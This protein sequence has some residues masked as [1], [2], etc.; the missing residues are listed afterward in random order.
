MTGEHRSVPT[1]RGAR[2]GV[3]LAA[4][5][6]GAWHAFERAAALPS[7]VQ[8]AVPILFFGD[9][10]T[11]LASPLR[12]LTV[13]LNPSLHEFPEGD[14]FRRFPLGAGVTRSEPDR[15]LDALSSYFRT[16]P[17]RR[18]FDSF[19]PLLNGLGSS[20]Y[21]GYPSTALHTDICSAVATDP[22]WTG[23]DE[24][25]S[26]ALGADGGPLWHTLLEA[27]R[28]DVV[29]LSVARRHLSRIEFEALTEWE[30]LCA[31]TREIRGSPRRHP[32]VVS[33]RWYSVSR[34]AAMFLFGPA[35]QT[36]LGRLGTGQK[37][38]AGGIA[39]EAWQRDR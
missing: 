3:D 4:A 39:L 23:L 1:A 8:P 38:E 18:W 28:P 32:V 17:Y 9:L 36:P 29:A 15:Y 31:F 2:A 21:V 5:V 19:E 30:T 22:T 6:D 24:A 35:A 11:Y 37:R 7:R 26:A 27:L 20:Y 33:A 16:D 34:E 12:V 10:D 25:A 13:G 14:P